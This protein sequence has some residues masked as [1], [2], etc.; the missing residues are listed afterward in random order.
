MHGKSC[1]IQHNGQDLF[2]GL[3]NPLRVGRYHSLIVLD[4]GLSKDMTITSRSASGEVMS[5]SNTALNLFGVQFHPESVLTEYGH[6][7]I[8]NF[9]ALP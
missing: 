7:L 8:N 5:F 1:L 9:L 6:E 2:Q 4:E 3:P